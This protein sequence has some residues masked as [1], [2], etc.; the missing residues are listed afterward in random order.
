MA[1]V[2]DAFASYLQSTLMDMAKDEVQML[3]GV[4]GE[5]E[6]MGKKLGD[7]KNF[8]AD[9][10]RKNI[11][12][13]TVQEWVG[14]LKR[15]MYE[16]TDILDLCQLKAM[17][18]VPSRADEGCFNPLLFCLR[19]P[20]HAHDIGTRIKALN[21]RLGA[22][23]QQSVD[24]NFVNLGSYADH[25]GKLHADHP[26]KHNRETSGELD[27]S[28]VVGEKIEEDTRA[29]VA[30]IMQPRN[31]VDGNLMV[32]AIVGVGGIGKTTLAQQLFNDET[33][34]SGFTKKIWLSVNKDFCESELLK[35]A[36]T[37]A[38]GDHHSAGNAKATLQRTLKNVLIG[39][40]TLLVLDDVWNQEA[41]ESV[42]KTPLINAVAR[43]SQVLIT[44]RDETVARM[45]KA[46]QPYHHVDELD[47]NDAWSLL[48]KQV[49]SI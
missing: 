20:I 16:A 19:N 45:I 31:K 34:K 36:I 27:R 18:R 39:Q 6:N 43:G 46:E 23:K 2:L 5:M 26:G 35:R 30:R 22:I 37:E 24:L 38:E 49:S 9:A 32:L 42:L 25:G 8:L 48:K 28:S 41:W 44:T 13:K 1:M 4:T 3:F 17:K 11:T 47:D 15:A 7:L 10:D 21:E 40:K 12:D 14:Q 33:I 29:L